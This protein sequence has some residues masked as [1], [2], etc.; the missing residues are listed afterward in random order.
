MTSISYPAWWN[1][2]QAGFPNIENLLKTLFTP[3]ISGITV[4]YWLPSDR[5]IEDTLAAGGGFLRIY[6]TGGRANYEEN[7]DEPNV[8]LAALTKSRDDSW[9]LIEF[10]RTGVLSQFEK[11]AVVPGTQHQ[12]KCEG[13]VVGP[14]YIPEQMRDERLVPATFTLHTWRLKSNSLRQAIGL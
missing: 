2:D 6:R 12:L 5:V 13:E 7:R 1:R 9:D 4:T 3:M 14:Q 11:A 10:A 8:Q